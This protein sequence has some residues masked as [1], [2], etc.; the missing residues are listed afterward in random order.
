MTAVTKQNI[1]ST[2]VLLTGVINDV[3]AYDDSS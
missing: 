3:K 2:V 1:R